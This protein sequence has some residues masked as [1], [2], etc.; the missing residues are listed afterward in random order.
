M[1]NSSSRPLRAEEKSLENIVPQEQ[2]RHLQE[3]K[4]IQ[5]T[6]VKVQRNTPANKAGKVCKPQPVLRSGSRTLTPPGRSTK[7]TDKSK[8]AAKSRIDARKL[9]KDPN[10]FYHGALVG[11]FLGATLSTIITNLIVKTF[12]SA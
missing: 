6:H 7:V 12:Q 2:A 11:S 4:S 3:D 10:A 8:S 5:I 1:S 9:K